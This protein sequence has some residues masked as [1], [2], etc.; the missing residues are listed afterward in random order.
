MALCIGQLL[1]AQVSKTLTLASAGTLS[2][3]LT[4]TEKTTITHLT[5]TGSIDVRDVKCMS[6]ELTV[7]A[8]LDLSGANVV[9]YSGSDGTSS[10]LTDYPANEMPAGAFSYNG[11]NVTLKNI[12][13]PNSVTSI[14]KNAFIGCAVLTSLT[15]PNSV[16]SIGE[17]TF[18]R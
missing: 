2:T 4:A 17:W 11:D 18:C 9:A 1:M 5:I 3:T 12:I 10:D 13:F 14:G 7:L 6:N 8:E 15:L 16:I